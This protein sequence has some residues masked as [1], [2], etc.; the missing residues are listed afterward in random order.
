M[1]ELI[2]SVTKKAKSFA[3]STTEVVDAKNDHIAIA[4]ELELLSL[5]GMDVGTLVCD[6]PGL[7]LRKMKTECF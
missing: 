5:Q 3:S 6:M 4:D 1:K 7:L 2:D